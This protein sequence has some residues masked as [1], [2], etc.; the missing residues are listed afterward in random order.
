VFFLATIWAAGA[1][2]RKHRKDELLMFLF[3]MGVPLFLFFF[4]YT[5]R[6]RV[7][8]NWIAPC[9]IPMFCLA[10]IY[11]ERR[12]R[13]GLKVVG[14]WLLAG[15]LLGAIPSILLHDTNLVQKATGHWLPAKVD[16]LRRVRAWETTAQMV[17][18]QRSKLA[19]EGKPTFIIG[20]HYGISGAMSFYIPEARDDPKD[21]P[22]V[23]YQSADVPKNQFFFWPSYTNRIGDNAIYARRIKADEPAPQRLLDE[24]E[25][26]TN[27][28]LT[29]AYYRGRVFRTIQI[30]ECRGVKANEPSVK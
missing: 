10:A 22:L 14:K 24:F 9:V 21:N 13:E 8:P 17:E 16:P 4:C 15:W 30:F 5:F 29:N 1:V 19:E 18:A 2:W 28:G 11:W 26:V 6:S 27:L 23:Y 3:S 20:G 12:Q 7:Q 25:S